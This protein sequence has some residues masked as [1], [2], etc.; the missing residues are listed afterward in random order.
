[1]KRPKFFVI[2]LICLPF[3]AVPLTNNKASEPQQAQIAF[4]S[5]KDGK[6]DI[7]IID[8]N[9]K[10]QRKLTKI[11]CSC[12][13]SQLA[14]SPDGQNIAFCIQSRVDGLFNIYVMNSDG[15][16][17]RNLT[18]NWGRN[19]CPAWSPDGKKI[20]FVHYAS[21]IYVMDSDG[22]NI[23]R[24]TWD[25]NDTCPSWSPDGQ[26]IV[27]SSDRDEESNGAIYIMDA[28]GEN[29]HRLTNPSKYDEDPEWSPNGDKIAFTS[30][31]GGHGRAIYIM[32]ADGT[33]IHRL[34]EEYLAHHFQ[35]SWSPDGRHIAF[36]SKR[37]ND[38][39]EIYIA[40]IDGKKLYRVTD[41]PGI[42]R[43]PTWNPTIPYAVFSN[44]KDKASWGWVKQTGK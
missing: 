25:M 5:I 2:L 24:L 40:S 33:D 21:G 15:T 28:D 4:V 10:N 41:H 30:M 7:Y 1:M 12:D 38:D 26:K 9:G 6:D 16:N 35:P 11:D 3:I 44:N 14:W 42:D 23:T 19:S 22:T 43:Y 34:S 29:I 8:A 13:Y 18:E 17:I 37:D 36:V 31:R 32:N 39:R 27:F 20:A